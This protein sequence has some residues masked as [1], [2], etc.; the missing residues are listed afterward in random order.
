M[1]QE[2]LKKLAQFRILMKKEKGAQIDFEKIFSDANYA[3]HNL[4][5]AEDSDNE[6]LVFL[7]L[8]LREQ[9]GLLRPTIPAA[10]AAEQ[11]APAPAPTPTASPNATKKYMFGARG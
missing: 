9:L 10:P 8:S 7:A 6:T 4:R 5:L 1:D 11:R 3:R 2:V